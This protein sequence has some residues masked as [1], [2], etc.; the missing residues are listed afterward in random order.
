MK[1]HLS[2][3]NPS[4]RAPVRDLLLSNGERMRLYDTRAQ[5]Y[6]YAL[7]PLMVSSLV[8]GLIPLP[9]GTPVLWPAQV[10]FER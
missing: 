1:T 6:T 3:S 4:I 5:S 9:S 2:G 8:S 10:E 7:I